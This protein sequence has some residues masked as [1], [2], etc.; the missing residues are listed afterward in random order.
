MLIGVLEESGA[1]SELVISSAWTASRPCRDE[2]DRKRPATWVRL[3]RECIEDLK[4]VAPEAG[5]VESVG[6]STTFP[7]TFAILRDGL[8]DADLV[9]LYDNTD[10]VGICCGDFEEWLGSAEAGTLNRMGPGNMA[11]GLVHLIRS[12]GLKIDETVAIV[13]PNTAFAFGLLSEIGRPPQPSSLL[14]DFT[15][16]T[17]GGLYDART[18]ERAPDGVGRL[19]DRVLPEIGSERIRS[20][21]PRAAPS[22]RNVLSDDAVAGAREVL[23]LPALRAVSIGA[24]DSPLGTLAFFPDS[25]TILNVRGSSDSPMIVVEGI[26]ERMTP[27]ET[28]L[29]YPMPT[30][31]TLAD[32]P[33]CVVAPMLRSGKVWDWVRRLRFPDGDPHGDAELEKLARKALKRRLSAPSG[34]SAGLRFDTAL[35]GERAPDWDSHATGTIAGL[36]ESHDLG[37][38][39]L[40]ALEGMSRTLGRCLCL[41]E[42]RYEVTPAKL[43][44][45][46]GPV[47]NA[48]WNWVTQVFTGKQVY[49]STFADASLL[50]AAMLGYAAGYDGAEQDSSVA[51]RLRALSRLASEHPP[52]RPIAVGPPDAELMALERDYRDS[53]SE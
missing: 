8:I 2:L 22:W 35:G 13:P 34:R 53:A 42:T 36:V 15:E 37:D 32:A 43:L 17:I 30:A 39:A 47:R 23:G 49:A 45:A 51:D 6:I 33:W 5:Q 48:L 16:T 12:C 40:A 19:L 21:L 38:I 7:G 18:G 9:S 50:G 10:D 14:S 11:I 31:T 24:G 26:R 1:P 25:D 41:M 28:V 52:I 3:I 20:L 29:H 44:L 46:G 4:K 27:R